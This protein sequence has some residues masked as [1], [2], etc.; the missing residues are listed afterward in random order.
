MEL[1][2]KVFCNGQQVNELNYTGEQATTELI[3]LLMNK[4]KQRYKI[5]LTTDHINNTIK[6]KMHYTHEL[7]NGK[8]NKY[9]YDFYFTQVNRNAIDL[10]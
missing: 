1:K 4:A 6:A 3:N 7:Y 8:V 10:R 9:V 2:T 5:S